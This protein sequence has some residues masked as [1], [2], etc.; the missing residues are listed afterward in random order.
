[1]EQWNHCAS[2]GALGC[3]SAEE[4]TNSPF[5]RCGK[6]DGYKLYLVQ[7]LVQMG[8]HAKDLIGKLCLDYFVASLRLNELS[9]VEFHEY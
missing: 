9:F 2:R 3:P 6:E 4:E 7:L 8:E 1:M 5:V